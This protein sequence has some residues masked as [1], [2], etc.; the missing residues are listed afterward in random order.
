MLSFLP[1]HVETFRKHFNERRL[2]SAA[3]VSHGG[4]T[5]CP[6]LGASDDL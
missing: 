4:G 5:I 1:I 2:R 3:T 6:G